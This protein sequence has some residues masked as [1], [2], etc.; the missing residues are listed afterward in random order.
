M[1][2]WIILTA[3][4][5]SFL[6][7]LLLAPWILPWLR[8]LKFSQSILEIGPSWH[9]ETKQGTPTIGGLIFIIPTILVTAVLG[10]G[11]MIRGDWRLLICLGFTILCGLIG[12]LDD[13]IKVVKKRNQG[14]TVMQKTLPL[15][16]IIAL[17]LGALYTTNVITDTIFIPYL[18]IR[19]HLF[20]FY[21]L[22][23]I[24]FVF[25]FVNAVNLTDGLDGLATGV[26]LPYMISFIVVGFF[27]RNAGSNTG[28]TV[29][30]AALTGG[31]LA[32]LIYNFHPAKV[33]MGDTGSLF[34]GAAVAALAMAYDLPYFI[35]IGGIM[36]LIEGLSVVMQVIFYK[37]TH[38]KRIFK[39]TPI[40]HHFEMCGWS[41]VKIVAV[42]T[43]I[44][45][46]G[47]LLA[48]WGMFYYRYFNV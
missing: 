8:R 40:H 41:E 29:F 23:M 42:F 46:I 48:L 16:L 11:E 13:Y 45:A 33:F 5:A 6:L 25:F 18:N 15:M 34:L 47:C 28:I 9:K 24:P 43:S 12:F 27:F 4:L 17:F 32:F 19:L 30:A 2:Y 20:Y 35:L 14:L 26:S 21:F 22:V 38:G 1:N 3:L 10:M 37:L 44:S 36:F 39:M 31:L 7:A